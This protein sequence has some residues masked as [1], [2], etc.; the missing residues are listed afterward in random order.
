MNAKK[1][2]V[3]L[4]WMMTGCLLSQATMSC[5]SDDDTS[6]GQNENRDD[7]ENNGDVEIST[8]D[9]LHCP[10]EVNEKKGEIFC[11]VPAGELT[12]DSVENE[13]QLIWKKGLT[14]VLDGKVFIGDDAEETVLT[15]EPGALILGET[16]TDLDNSASLIIQRRSKIVAEGTADDPIVFT[17]ARAVGE[18]AND[19][20]GGIVINGRAPI[21]SCGSGSGVCEAAGE[22]ETGQFGGDDPDDDSGVFRYVRIEFS[23]KR[24]DPTKEFNG[25]TLQGVGR[26]TEI[27]HVQIH[28]AGD[29]AIEFFGGTAEV[30]HMVLSGTGDDNFDW[31]HGWQGKAQFIIA[32]TIGNVSGECGIEA[33]NFETNFDYT[34]RS[35]PTLYN[36]SFLGPRTSQVMLFRRGTAGTFVNFLSLASD[37]CLDIADKAT[38]DMAKSGALTMHHS[39]FVADDCFE[40]DDLEGLDNLESEWW[41][42]EEGNRVV[43]DPGVE[44]VDAASPDYRL[45]ADSPLWEGAGAIPEGD[46]FFEAVDFIGAMGDDDWTAGWTDYPIN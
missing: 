45:K 33:D 7:T 4:R 35:N 6:S 40:D 31:T 2:V 24:L 19:D 17:S 5:G 37:R 34:P 9:V 22:G 44:K 28:K 42:Q 25:L 20:W 29:D 27:H 13:A 21:N 26:G 38:W 18:R 11:I 36:F 39:V 23:G 32:T 1:A 15:I 16:V 8:D 46:D 14:Y 10:G 30:H 12:A 3:Y 43:A 41:L